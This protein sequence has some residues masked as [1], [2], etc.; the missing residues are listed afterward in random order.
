MAARESFFEFRERV[1]SALGRR[2]E[3]GESPGGS[4][5]R[6]GAQRPNASTGPQGPRTQ[7]GEPPHYLEQDRNAVTAVRN[8]GEPWIEVRACG[9]RS[10]FCEQC[11]LSKGIEL[12]KR[13][14]P[15]LEKFTGLMMLTFTID[16]ELFAGPVEAFEYVKK[17]RCVAVA[18]QRLHRWGFLHSR[19]YLQVVEWQVNGWA[20]WHVLVDASR[21]P[22]DKLC[23][24]WNRNWKGWKERVSGGRPGF[25]SVRF[26]KERVERSSAAGYVV[27]Y[28]VKKPERGYPE[29]V[30][31]SALRSVRRFEASRGFWSAE[32]SPEKSSVT[33]QGGEECDEEDDEE[34]PLRTIR[35]Q[36]AECGQRCVVLSAR[37]VVDLATGE[38]EVVRE[39]LAAVSVPLSGVV[40]QGPECEVNKRGT[41][42]VYR[43]IAAFVQG[44][45]DVVPFIPG[46]M[47]DRWYHGSQ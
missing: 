25:G 33:D 17:K 24:A 18:L 29:W 11:C 3:E 10:W 27:A 8:V 16:P 9:C 37:E 34:K 39:F 35:Q 32:K 20:H 46:G 21:I 5:P 22:F 14:K 7:G 45:R 23:E 6:T 12:K 36:V 31:G 30:E 4:G 41:S 47:L 28:L 15:E 38:A 2:D 1:A 40:S 44:L 19:R 43:N 26:S 42:A 13:L